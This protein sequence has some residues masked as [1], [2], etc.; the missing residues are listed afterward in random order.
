MKDN[1]VKWGIII[2][3]LLFM[4]AI[5]LFLIKPIDQIEESVGMGLSID[6]YA[7]TYEPAIQSTEAESTGGIAIPGWDTIRLEADREEVSANLLNPSDNEG[8]YNLT[9]T[10]TIDGEDEPITVTGLI[11]PGKSALQLTLS[12]ALPAGTYNAT[13]LIQ[14]YRISDGSAANNA[15]IKTTLVVE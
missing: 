4:A 7:G 14:P 13:V 1:V 5:V 2:L 11:P 12:K 6:P 9:F 3:T 8:R 15:E 10:I